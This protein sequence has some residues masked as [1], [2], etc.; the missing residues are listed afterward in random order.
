MVNMSNGCA[1]GRPDHSYHQ[2]SLYKAASII[3]IA[4]LQHTILSNTTT[5]LSNKKIRHVQ[6]IRG[7][8]VWYKRGV[9]LISQL[10]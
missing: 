3:Y 7:I 8:V 6:N 5:P 10:C 2:H 1:D 4:K 9:S